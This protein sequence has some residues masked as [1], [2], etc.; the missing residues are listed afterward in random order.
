MQV[1]KKNHNKDEDNYVIIQEKI[2]LLKE[3]LN[4]ALKNDSKKFNMQ[5]IAHLWFL[6]YCFLLYQRNRMLPYSDN[7]MQNQAESLNKMFI[8]E[9]KLSTSQ[10]RALRLLISIVH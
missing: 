1:H 7:L 6:D 4:Q 3:I 10:I 5:R 2:T 9:A 8:T